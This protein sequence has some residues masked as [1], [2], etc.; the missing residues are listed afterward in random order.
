MDAITAHAHEHVGDS[1]LFLGQREGL[2]LHK[3]NLVEAAINGLEANWITH[4]VHF[5]SLNRPNL[6][7]SLLDR[8]LVRVDAARVN[9]HLRARAQGHVVILGA[10]TGVDAILGIKHHLRDA[11]APRTQRLDLVGDDI[12][13]DAIRMQ[14]GRT[15]GN[16]LMPAGPDNHHRL[17]LKHVIRD[18]VSLVLQVAP[19]DPAVADQ[20]FIAAL[21][22]IAGVLAIS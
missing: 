9:N 1:S 16:D 17:V 21:V 5:A 10:F 20:H 14:L 13:R 4:V 11:N 2:I 19:A 8:R 7:C 18:V 6:A 3:L 15:D 12:D 22:A